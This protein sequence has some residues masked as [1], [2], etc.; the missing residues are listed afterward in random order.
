MA[1]L[2]GVT[3]FL[4]MWINNSAATS[5]M[6]P[7]AVAIIDELELHEKE[8]QEKAANP[9]PPGNENRRKSK[10]ILPMESTSMNLHILII[11]MVNPY[12]YLQLYLISKQLLNRKECHLRKF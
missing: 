2:M 1:G 6:I 7:A 11:S 12:H 8:M 5:I 10:D 4:S 3:A 9:R